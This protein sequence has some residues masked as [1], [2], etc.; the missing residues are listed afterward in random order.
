[1]AP[2][3]GGSS[4]LSPQSQP[5]PS[6]LH[7]LTSEAR[8][9]SLGQVL[10]LR[11]CPRGVP[12]HSPPLP[13]VKAP[14]SVPSVTLTLSSSSSLPPHSLE[15]L[16]PA[17]LPALPQT[18]LSHQSSQ[19]CVHSSA[20]KATHRSRDFIPNEMGARGGGG[21]AGVL[22]LLCEKRRGQGRCRGRG[23]G[24]GSGTLKSPPGPPHSPGEDWKSLSPIQEA[25]GYRTERPRRWGRPALARGSSCSWWLHFTPAE[26]EAGSERGCCPPCAG[27]DLAKR[28]LA[29]QP[30][31]PAPG[32]LEPSQ[33]VS[34]HPVGPGRPHAT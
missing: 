17:G 21:R 24:P 7:Q 18:R 3:L 8:P 31:D 6:T 30:W 4:P 27:L 5:V 14:L 29:A 16:A 11:C 2:A 28:S 25:Q 34:D 12:G 23:G 20:L 10:S 22:Q 33:E 32:G 15:T 26:P 13:P 1:M 19:V 9:C